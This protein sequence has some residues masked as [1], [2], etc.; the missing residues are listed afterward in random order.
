MTDTA[1]PAPDPNAADDTSRREEAKAKVQQA[2]ESLKAELATR[3]DQFLDEV[4]ALI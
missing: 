3:L 1:T 2:V 4:G